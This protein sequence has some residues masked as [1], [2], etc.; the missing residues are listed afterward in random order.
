MKILTMARKLFFTV[1]AAALA[2]WAYGAYSGEPQWQQWA[3][4]LGNA[5]ALG[6]AYLVPT[7]TAALVG[8]P[9][10]KLV[11]AL[12]ILGGWLILP[13]IAAMMLALKRDDLAARS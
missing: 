10:L 5:L 1:L 2:L 13:W 6:G 12:N 8:S 7:L 4:Y 11:A 3:M 9:R